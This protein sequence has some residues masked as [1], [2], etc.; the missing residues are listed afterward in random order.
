MPRTLGDSLVVPSG[1]YRPGVFTPLAKVQE[2]IDFVIATGA[3]RVWFRYNGSDNQN[4]ARAIGL[5]TTPAKRV[6][7]KAPVPG[8]Y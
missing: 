7:A 8:E 1:E 5:V 2:V 3:Q 4:G 6:R